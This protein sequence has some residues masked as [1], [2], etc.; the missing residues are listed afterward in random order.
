MGERTNGQRQAGLAAFRA[1]V[2]SQRVRR[3]FM[4]AHRW[5][6]LT[7]GIVVVL[8][9][10]TG[11]FLVFYREIDAALN[12][13]LYAPAGP[14][15]SVT[16]IDVMRAAA[17]ADTAPISTIVAPDRAWPV[18]VVMH[19]HES[20]KGRYPNLWT[21]MVDP[22]NGRVLGRRDYTNS[23]AFTIYRLHHTLLLYEWWGKELVGVVGFM[24]FGSALSGLYLWWPRQGRFWR[25]MS[26]RKGV[27]RQRFVIDIHNT[28]GFW[29]LIALVVISITGAGI[30]FPGVVRPVVGLLSQA[31]PYPSPRIESPPP[32][33]TPQLPPDAIVRVARAAKPGLMIAMLDP[34]TE[35]RN[36]WRVLFRSEGADPAVRSRGAIWLDPWSGAVVHDRT[37]DAMQ[38]GDRYMTEQLWLHNG[39]TFGLVG[40]LLVFIAGFAPLALVISGWMI[41]LGKPPR[42]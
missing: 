11:S 33:G 15:Q 26:V 34:P 23:F 41:W 8:V 30:I 22:S 3:A 25:S 5:L 36:T 32:K 35:I 42:K 7:G 17:A 21:T 38:M 18:W 28:A 27:S 39:A 29:A 6:G 10:L 31:T 19:S 9:G 4:W 2:R 40:R 12:P 1:A 14:D 24:L 16:L 20:E 13:A 37:S